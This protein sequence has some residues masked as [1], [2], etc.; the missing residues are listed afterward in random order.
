MDVGGPLV[1]ESL[2]TEVARRLRDLILSGQLPPGMRLHQEALS[3]SLGISRTPMRQALALLVEEG[4]V[5]RSPKS[6]YTVATLDRESLYDL[7]LVRRELDGLAAELAA[8]RRT[9]QDLQALEAELAI[10]EDADPHQWLVHHQRFHLLIYAASRNP[11]LRRSENTV[12]LSTRLFHPQLTA[13]DARRTASFQEQRRIWEAI[14][15]Q[16]GARAREEAREH[17]TQAMAVLYPE[18]RRRTSS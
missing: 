16:D 15:A 18:P 17:I 5:D 7:Y 10:M 1:K 13:H 4:F 6:Q 14:A 3:Q 9:E 8:E 2:V 12:L 11:H